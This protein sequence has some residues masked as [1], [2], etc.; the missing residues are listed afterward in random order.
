MARTRTRWTRSQ[1]RKVLDEV[2]ATG[3]SLAE[4]ARQRGLQPERLSR[5]RVRFEEE[6]QAAP[7]R[8]VE[9]VPS[10]SPP[11]MAQRPAPPHAEVRTQLHIRCPSGHVVEL[12]EVELRAGL[13]S[14]FSAMARVQP[15]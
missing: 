6:A 8:M 12:G 11:A 10:G 5:W 14:I 2:E 3:L 13:Q 15:C 4:F 7:P 1:A 9:L